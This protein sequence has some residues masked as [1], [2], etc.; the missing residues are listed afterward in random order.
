QYEMDAINR[1]I[2]Y[3]V[4]SQRDDGTWD[5]D[6]FT[7]TGF[8]CHFYL[9]YHL[10]YQNF[11]LMTLGRYRSL[12]GNQQTLAIPLSLKTRDAEAVSLENGKTA[13]SST[14]S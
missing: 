14:R 7:G 5:E 6:Y 1:G 2:A 8:P 4:N 3:L 10:Y 11:P 13:E 12:L 9:K